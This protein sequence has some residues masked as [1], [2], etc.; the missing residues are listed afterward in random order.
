MGVGSVARARGLKCVFFFLMIR[1]P[2]R[3]TLFPYTTLFR[4]I[5]LSDAPSRIR[6]IR[7]LAAAGIVWFRGKRHGQGLSW[8]HLG[9]VCGIINQGS[10]DRRGLHE[11]TRLGMVLHVQ[12]RAARAC[13]SVATIPGK[14]KLLQAPRLPP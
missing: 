14:L 10:H 1:R 6:A 2:P 11:I 8:Q 3:S 4:S 13:P 7:L 5:S 12:L 9:A